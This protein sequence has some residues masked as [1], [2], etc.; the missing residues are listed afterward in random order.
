MKDGVT[1]PKFVVTALFGALL[2]IGGW[3]LS[4]LIKLKEQV[5]VLSTEMRMHISS[6]TLKTTQ[7]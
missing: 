6:C 5:S 2:T 1:I 7:R 3:Q 4:E